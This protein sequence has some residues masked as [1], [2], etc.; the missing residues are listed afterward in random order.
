MRTHLIIAVLLYAFLPLLFESCESQN[1]NLHRH[2]GF[3][4]N[5]NNDVY[6]SHFHTDDLHDDNLERWR[7]IDHLDFSHILSWYPLVLVRAKETDDNA[8]GP[9]YTE[10]FGHYSYWDWA[11]SDDTHVLF[12]YVINAID[13]DGSIINTHNLTRDKI[14]KVYELYREDLERLDWCISYS[15]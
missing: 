15:E 4:N 8:I 1:P 9:P 2:I 12:V 7:N 3:I 5:T 10:D 6:V 14:I 13:E 11:F